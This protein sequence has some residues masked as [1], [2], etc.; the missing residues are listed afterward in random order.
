MT[1]THFVPSLL[2]DFV[3][4]PAARECTTLREVICSGEALSAH[5]RDRFHS[6][7]DAGLNNLYGPTGRRST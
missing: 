4:E 7:L 3:Q 5:L 2:Q 1:V 6:V